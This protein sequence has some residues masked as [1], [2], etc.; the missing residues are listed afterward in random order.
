VSRNYEVLVEVFPC[1]ATE[2]ASI[3]DTLSHWGL[4]VVCNTAWDD[5]EHGDGHAFW[6]NI[7]LCGGVTEE[8]QHDRLRALLPNRAV[9][10]RW[11]W[12]DDQPW[13]DVIS[14]GPMRATA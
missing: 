6:G 7:E 3:K 10:T 12:I 14:T 13:H 9:T 11:R 1:A 4:T 2:L 8:E 5:H